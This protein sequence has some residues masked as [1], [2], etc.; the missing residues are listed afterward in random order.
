MGI[1]YDNSFKTKNKHMKEEIDSKLWQQAKARA[2][3]KTHLAAYTIINGSLWLIWLFTG[4]VY[5]YP[6]PIWPTIGWGIGL[7]FNYLAVYKF[8]N[9][10]E[11]EY[12]KLK[13]G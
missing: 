8:N 1:L 11:R 7:V 3:F 6:W 5:S 10:A 2:E 9:T 13:K 12:E 4:G